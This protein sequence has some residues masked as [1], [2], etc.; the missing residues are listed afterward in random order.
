MSMLENQ[1]LMM[2]EYFDQQTDFDKKSNINTSNDKELIDLTEKKIVTTNL[3]FNNLMESAKKGSGFINIFVKGTNSDPAKMEFNWIMNQLVTKNIHINDF[4]YKNSG[5]K[6]KE[7][8]D[9][10]L[11]VISNLKINVHRMIKMVL[12]H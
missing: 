6:L 5:F 7:M 8:Y 1:S 2:K 11:N 10:I 9:K 3:T 4:T 12:N